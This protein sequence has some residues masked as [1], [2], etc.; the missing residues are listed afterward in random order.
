MSPILQSFGNADLRAFGFTRGGGA[1][2]NALTLIST[3]ILASTAA[4]VTFSSI[5]QTYKHLQV[6]I[7]SRNA[8]ASSGG[9]IYMIPN[10]IANTS[11]NYHYLSGNGSTVS[12]GSIATG[13]AYSYTVNEY[14]PGGNNAAG[15]FGATVIDILDYTSTAK[16]KTSRSFWGM[17][18]AATATQVE[19]LSQLAQTTSA[20]TQLAFTEAATGFAAGSRI[21]LYGVLG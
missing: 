15:I 5:P 16:N 7:T 8:S 12:S 2:G 19:L 3:Q 10:S 18:N 14:T 11:V 1:G 21:S 6:R 17:V 13:F 20:I 9:S 4:T